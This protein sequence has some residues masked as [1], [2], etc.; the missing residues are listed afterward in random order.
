MCFFTYYY[1]LVVLVP[2]VQDLDQQSHTIIS[3]T[4]SAATHPYTILTI[5]PTFTVTDWEQAKPIMDD[6][7]AR[8]KTEAGCV[9]YGWVK[10]GNTLK[11]R[12][13]YVD[14]DAV[15]AHL[16]NVGECIQAIL[17]EGVAKLDSINIQGPADQLEIVK[18]GTEA[19]GTKYYATDGGFTQMA[20][21]N[22]GEEGE[23]SLCSIHPTFTVTDWAKAKPIMEDFIARTKT[24]AGCVYYGWVKEGNTLKCREAYVDGDAVNAHLANVGECIQAILA[25]G[26]AKLDSI[27]IQGPAAQLEIVKPGTEALGTKYYATDGGFSKYTR[28]A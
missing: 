19:L 10:E 7:I 21:A 3:Q 27:N 18:P 9:Y 16:A 22:G 8:T 24:E 5:H 11:C 13:A 14:G 2:S 4:M 23:Y 25:E 12:E 1:Y 26:V 28:S 15:N 17:A 20:S 6:F